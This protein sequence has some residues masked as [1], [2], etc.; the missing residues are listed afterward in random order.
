MRRG[1]RAHRVKATPEQWH[2]DDLWLQPETRNGI[3]VWG[4]YQTAEGY[5]LRTARVLAD[6][7][8]GQ[9]VS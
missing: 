9:V 2:A 1:L 5:D 8:D 4:A 7:F 3:A 6:A